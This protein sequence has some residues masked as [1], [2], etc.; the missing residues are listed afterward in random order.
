[1]HRSTC[2]WQ[3]SGATELIRNAHQHNT[4]SVRNTMHYEPVPNSLPPVRLHLVLRRI[5]DQALRVRERNVRRRRAVALVV[6]DD[7][8]GVVLPDAH[9]RVGRAKVNAN[10]RRLLRHGGY[11]KQRSTGAV[12]C[13]EN[14]ILTDHVRPD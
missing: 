2:R 13:H 5:T 10:S 1:M 14:R 3:D 9:A 12:H 4:V 6:R 11:E 7:V 8:H